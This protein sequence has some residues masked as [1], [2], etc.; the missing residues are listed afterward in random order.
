PGRFLVY[1]D[2][3]LAMLA[4]IGADVLARP[5]ARRFVPAFQLLVTGWTIFAFGII[6]LAAP[7]VYIRLFL[8]RAQA[9]SAVDQLQTATSSFA[10]IAFFIL[11]TLA[12]LIAYRYRWI[13][14]WSVAAVAIALIVVDLYGNNGGINPTTVDPTTGFQHP[15]VNASLDRTLGS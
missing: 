8:N 6:A 2:F 14:G 12:L 13:R 7:L 11:A 1:V 4:G 9:E 5:L 10:L 3:G 15:V